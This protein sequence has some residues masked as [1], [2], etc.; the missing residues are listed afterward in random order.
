MT[1]LGPSLI[2]DISPIYK[3]LPRVNMSLHE[4]Q[5]TDDRNRDEES[6]SLLLSNKNK[7]RAAI[8]R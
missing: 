4:K 6:L 5:P 2:P 8:Y 1:S 3:P 7:G